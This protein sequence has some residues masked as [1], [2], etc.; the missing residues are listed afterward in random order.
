VSFIRPED[1]LE[2][3]HAVVG[4]D[5]MKR[6]LASVFSQYTLYLQDEEAERPVACIYG[7]SGAGKTFAIETLSDSLELPVTVVSAP[8]ISMAS[9]KGATLRQILVQHYL[10]FKRDEGII[11]VDELDKWCA[12]AIGLDIESRTMG[13]RLQAEMLR[14]VEAERVEFVDEYDEHEELKDEAT[15]EI[16]VFNTKRILWVFA[17]AFLGLEN[18]I[19][20]RLQNWQNL[21]LE[22]V[23]AQ[24]TAN[25]FELYG[26]LRELVGRI[27]TWAFAKPLTAVQLI[28]ILGQQEIPR[29]QRR[30]RAVGC[31]LEFDRGSLAE[32]AN[33]AYEEKTGARGAAA[34]LRRAMDD[35]F[36][37]ASRHHL[38][39]LLVTDHLIRTGHLELEAV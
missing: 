18:S 24:A 26:M 15:G 34:A 22:W 33:H 36:L 32:C 30:F 12:G 3:L 4:Q 17:G 9:H 14:Y 29:W 19:R 1:L 13:R 28:E 39:S 2:H 6:K 38:G 10:N 11:L 31:E 20:Q 27:Q 5:D 23:L 7:P 35:L 8:S 37:E 25:D 16:V 21:E